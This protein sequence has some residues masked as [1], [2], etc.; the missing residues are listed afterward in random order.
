MDTNKY[1][2]N[3]ETISILELI[4]MKRDAELHLFNVQFE[5]FRRGVDIDD[6]ARGV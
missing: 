5:L 2:T 1:K 3:F 6:E 4:N